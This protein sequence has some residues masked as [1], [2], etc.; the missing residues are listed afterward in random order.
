[1]TNAAEIRLIDLPD[2]LSQ[3]ETEAERTQW[4]EA[5]L[6]WA[7]LQLKAGKNDVAKDAQ[8]TFESVL[9]QIA[10]EQ[11]DG[12]R[13]LAAKRLG[14]GRNTLTRKIKELQLVF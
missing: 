11:C 7:E 9:I 6:K 12:H 1:M 3:L 5:L 4:H 14:Y 2:E 10:M 13:Y 8:A